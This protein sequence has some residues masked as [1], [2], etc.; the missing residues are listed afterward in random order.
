MREMEKEYTQLKKTVYDEGKSVVCMFCSCLIP[1]LNILPGFD[2]A[3]FNAT[4]PTTTSIIRGQT[5]EEQAEQLAKTGK[6]ASA[7]NMY[8]YLGSMM[9]N[10]KELLLAREIARKKKQEEQQEKIDKAKEKE[11]ELFRKA[12][13]AYILFHEKGHLLDRLTVNE[14]KYIV[15]FSL[16]C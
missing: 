3:V 11:A 9:Y 2:T 14:L 7:G 16:L 10:S 13:E 5:E 12:E 8:R 15:R 1:R 6:V 4:L